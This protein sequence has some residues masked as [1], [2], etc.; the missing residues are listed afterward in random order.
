[1]EG[2]KNFIVAGHLSGQ[3]LASS[4]GGNLAIM[5]IYAAQQMSA[6]AAALI[7]STSP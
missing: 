7:E 1:M 4:F 2:P 6:E 5:D 3:G